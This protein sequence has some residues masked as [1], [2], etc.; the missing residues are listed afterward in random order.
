MIKGP[1]LVCINFRTGTAR[2]YLRRTNVAVA[3]MGWELGRTHEAEI[4]PKAGFDPERIE[5][6]R[7]AGV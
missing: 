2:R 7:V 1:A 5:R 4:D 6:F 3:G